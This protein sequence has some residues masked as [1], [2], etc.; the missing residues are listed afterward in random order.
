MKRYYVITTDYIIFRYHTTEVVLTYVSMV[1]IVNDLNTVNTVYTFDSAVTYMH[2][3]TTILHYW[4]IQN[5]PEINCNLI[6]EYCELSDYLCLNS[7]QFS[8]RLGN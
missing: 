4:N 7:N 5:S 6:S 3:P 8:R 1:R 2:D